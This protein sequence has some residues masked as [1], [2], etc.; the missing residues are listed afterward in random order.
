M[1]HENKSAVRQ[2]WYIR[3]EGRVRGAYPSSEI[4]HQLVIGKISLDDMISEDKQTWHELGSVPEVMPLEMRA[5]RGDRAA[6]ALLEARS[7]QERGDDDQRSSMNGVWLP[8]S[9][10]ISVAVVAVVMTV[11]LWEPTE[12]ADPQCS[13]VPAPGVDW[14]YCRKSGLNLSGSNFSGANLTS[15][16][17]QESD[18]SESNFQGAVLNYGNFSDADLSYSDLSGADLKGANLVNAK[19]TYSN[20][21]S[22]NLSFADLTGASLGGAK[23]DNT[24]LDH[25]IWLDGRTCAAGSIDECITTELAP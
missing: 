20:L 25:A 21:T 24:H 14:R 3:H 23:L 2:L 16:H 4:R 22:A 7:E 19:L 17:F 10:L 15:A 1:V 13:A 18:F 11:W 12:I 5:E 9:I 6:K 8:F